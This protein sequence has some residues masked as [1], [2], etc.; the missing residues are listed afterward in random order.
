MPNK[1][2]T[3]NTKYYMREVLRDYENDKNYEQA[4]EECKDLLA[5]KGQ[6]ATSVY[7]TSNPGP[8][9]PFKEKNITEEQRTYKPN[10]AQ[11]LMDACEKKVK[12]STLAWREYI[13]CI[14][15]HKIAVCVS[16]SLSLRILLF[17]FCSLNIVYIFQTARSFESKY[18]GW[19][20]R[21]GE[22][23]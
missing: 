21:R 16:F 19:T 6:L 17:I 23:P 13:D 4:F 2:S 3:G 10:L 14:N 12:N 1:T 9:V 20:G 22:N 18:F 8:V 11:I 7:G 15:N 5:A